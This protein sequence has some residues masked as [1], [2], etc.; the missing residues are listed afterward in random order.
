LQYGFVAERKTQPFHTPDEPPLPMTYTGKLPCQP[1][2]APSHFGPVFFVVDVVHDIPLWG[3]M[4]HIHRI[5]KN[6]LRI[7]CG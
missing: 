7:Y 1:L 3:I 5:S 4:P 6:N 2:L